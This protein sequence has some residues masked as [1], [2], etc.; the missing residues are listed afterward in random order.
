M[1]VKFQDVPG[2]IY[3]DNSSTT[4]PFPRVAE[5]MSGVLEDEFGN[6]S[7]LHRLDLNQKTAKKSQSSWHP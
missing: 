3:M 6:P 2:I 5:V 4:R 1:T 7:S